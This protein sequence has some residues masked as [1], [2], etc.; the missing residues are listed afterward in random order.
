MV[1]NGQEFAE[2]HWLPEDD[3]GSGRRVQSRPLHWDYCHDVFGKALCEVYRKL[4]GLRMQYPVLR[5]DGFVPDFWEEWQT[6]FNLDGVGV[7]CNRQLSYN[8]V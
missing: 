4:I 1:Q 8:F 6:Q 3:K 5:A 2:D 7:D